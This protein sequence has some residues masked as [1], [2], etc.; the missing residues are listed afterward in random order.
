M[1]TEEDVLD[2]IKSDEWM[3][4]IINATKS[5]N[6]PDWWVCAGFV[7]S[8]V[9][10][11]LHGYSQRTQMP[12]IDVIYFDSKE[13]SEEKE[14]QLERELMQIYPEAP[15]SVK[16]QARMHT[17][18][19]VSPYGSSLDAMSKFP[20]TATAIGVKLDSENKLVLA[21]PCGIQDLVNLTVKPTSSFQESAERVTIYENRL[22]EK[23]WKSTWP[24][25]TLFHAEGVK[26]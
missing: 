18:N 24:N 3:M 9:W 25:I 26:S 2:L 23:N 11:T 15:W 17:I 7:R 4:E 16:N 1:Q 19:R 14:K 10:D 8:K 12:D 21:A 20:E 22:R 5:L 6:L 13:L